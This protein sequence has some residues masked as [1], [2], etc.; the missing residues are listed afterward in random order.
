[1][2]ETVLK[3]IQWTPM[4]S[5]KKVTEMGKTTRLMMSRKVSPMFQ[6]TLQ[7]GLLRELNE[8]LKLLINLFLHSRG[9]L[10]SGS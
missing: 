8:K 1:M 3:T 2:S 4:S 9:R 6:Y 10:L 7:K 5:L